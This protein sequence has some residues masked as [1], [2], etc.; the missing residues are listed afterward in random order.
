MWHVSL[1]RNLTLS[2]L[3]VSPTCLLKG[4]TWKCNDHF[5]CSCC[6]TSLIRFLN[7]APFQL[8]RMVH[9]CREVVMVENKCHMHCDLPQLCPQRER[10]LLSGTACRI[11]TLPTL[12][13]EVCS[14]R[15][16]HWIVRFRY[17]ITVNTRGELLLC[18]NIKCQELHRFVSILKR[19]MGRTGRDHIHPL[20]PD[21]W[22]D[23]ALDFYSWCTWPHWAN[24][25]IP[26]NDMG[27]SSDPDLT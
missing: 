7:K 25:F 8:E 19:G 9:S 24:L 6:P 17:E 16:N 22:K 14:F 1:C 27:G 12:L 13:E 23:L 11:Q 4:V 2:P 21:L 3:S 26:S 5:K 15:R 10:A 18:G 20:K